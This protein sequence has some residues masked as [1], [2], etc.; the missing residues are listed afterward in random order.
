MKEVNF[1]YTNAVLRDVLSDYDLR[2]ST[3]VRSGF[4]VDCFLLVNHFEEAVIT[5]WFGKCIKKPL[6]NVKNYNELYKQF[7][8]V[9]AEIDNN[10]K[11][12]NPS[13][14]YEFVQQ[15]I[16]AGMNED[17]NATYWLINRIAQQLKD[18]S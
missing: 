9:G 3:D 4:P 6:L 1:D 12:S 18:K 16:D 8:N 10:W 15:C 17:D 13:Q 14:G 5:F 11:I 2:Q 7:T